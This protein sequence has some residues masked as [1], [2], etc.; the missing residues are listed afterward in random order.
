M[1]LIILILANDNNL[2]LEC[3]QIWKSYMS[4]HPF[5]DSYFLK[6]NSNLDDEIKLE[7]DT[8][9]IKGNESLVPG[10][11]DKTIKS[12]EFILNNFEFDFI[13][14]TNMSS[15]FDLDKLYKILNKEINCAGVV[16][17]INNINFISGAGMVLS[18]NICNNLIAYKTN[19]NYNIM[20]DVSIGKFISDNNY[21]ITPLTRFEAYLC[22]DKVE[23]ITKET[24]Q[25]YYHFR[26]KC[27]NPSLTIKLMK[28]IINLIYGNSF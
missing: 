23:E 12:I 7:N 21:A 25:E 14:R 11:L 28:K 26:C 4:N 17:N 20:D 22:K 18:K 5:I 3:Q 9:L 27:D 6:Y 8:I 16:G 15:V 1:K 2:Y 19:L 13:L 10:C 24:I